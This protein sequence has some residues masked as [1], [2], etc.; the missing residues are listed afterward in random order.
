MGRVNNNNIRRK[1]KLKKML[2]KQKIEA[3]IISLTESNHSKIGGHAYCPDDLAI[4]FFETG[5]EAGVTWASEQYAGVVKVFEE[6]IDITTNVS[7]IPRDVWEKGLEE[8]NKLK[9][10]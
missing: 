8:L 2:N 1:I 3:A 6:M 10:P 5:A 7:H 9:Q 4:F